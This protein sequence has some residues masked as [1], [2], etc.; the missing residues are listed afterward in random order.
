MNKVQINI[1]YSIGYKIHRSAYLRK[2]EWHY[3]KK[4]TPDPAAITQP[5]ELW[6]AKPSEQISIGL[7]WSRTPNR[8]SDGVRDANSSPS[9]SMFQL[10]LYRQFLP[11]GHSHAGDWT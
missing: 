9:K 8:L 1:N 7:R 2:K 6:S 3:F 11:P 4:F 10:R 5:L